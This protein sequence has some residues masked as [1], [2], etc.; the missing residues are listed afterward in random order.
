MSPESYDSFGAFLG[1]LL[2]LVGIL[3]FGFGGSGL[4][5]LWRMEHPPLTYAVDVLG[6]LLW[7]AVGVAALAGAVALLWGGYR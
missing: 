5:D 3:C 4:R 7:A 1:L 2:A 6:Y